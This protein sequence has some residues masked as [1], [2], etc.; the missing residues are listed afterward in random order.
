MGPKIIPLV[1][2]K[3]LDSKNFVGLILYDDLQD[4][5]LMK[6]NYSK[7]D[8]QFLEGEQNRALRTIKLW[9]KSQ[10]F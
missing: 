8:L 10:Q 4:N 1:L 7:N 9:L 6:I 5:I 3:I 2:E